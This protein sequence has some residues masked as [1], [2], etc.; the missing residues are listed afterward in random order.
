MGVRHV[1]RSS[2]QPELTTVY[3]PVSYTGRNTSGFKNTNWRDRM[4]RGQIVAS[5]YVGTFVEYKAPI[6]A[7][8]VIGFYSGEVLQSRFTFKGLLGNPYYE[9]PVINVPPANVVECDYAVR[10]KLLKKIAERRPQIDA[11]PYYTEWEKTRV[12]HKQM[13]EATVNVF[14][15]I[16]LLVKKKGLSL[17][18]WRNLST[19]I[20]GLWLAWR[21]AIKPTIKDLKVVSENLAAITIGRVESLKAGMSEP[22]QFRSPAIYRNDTRVI[23]NLGSSYV[24]FCTQVETEYRVGYVALFEEKINL[25]TAGNLW[26]VEEFSE[27]LNATT[28]KG[29]ASNIWEIIP[30]SW[31]VDYFTHISNMWANDPIILQDVKLCTKTIRATTTYTTTATL[32]H[33]G[34]GKIEENYCGEYVVKKSNVSR[35]IV[36]LKL[37]PEFYEVPGLCIDLNPLRISYIL[38]VIAQL[39]NKRGGLSSLARTG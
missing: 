28:L 34:N 38:S 22:Y 39:T 15:D 36:D 12:L 19:D 33:T 26:L 30:F 16:L 8:Y 10:Q 1:Q 20:A 7:Y 3:T 11:L 13:F 14:D 27:M 17:K 9:G 18:A 24:R 2:G 35:E 21:F 31:L 6:D 5:G 37:S 23:A 25:D 4:A 29:V 32:V